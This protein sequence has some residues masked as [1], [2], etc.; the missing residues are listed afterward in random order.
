MRPSTDAMHPIGL[1]SASAR[2]SGPSPLLEPRAAATR[3]FPTDRRSS[4]VADAP[5]SRAPGENQLLSSARLRPR[6]PMPRHKHPAR[7]EA[8]LKVMTYLRPR[9]RVKLLGVLLFLRR[10]PSRS[11]SHAQRWSLTLKSLRLTGKS[12]RLRWRPL[13]ADFSFAVL[14]QQPLSAD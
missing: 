12:Q 4:A 8:A 2:E 9:A 11:L 14:P 10:N 6:R 1:S 13:V 7:S 3:L 5:P